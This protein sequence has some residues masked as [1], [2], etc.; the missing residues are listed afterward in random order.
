MA[1]LCETEGATAGAARR[2]RRR[3]ALLASC[4]ANVFEEAREVAIKA[5]EHL[6]DRFLSGAQQP[7]RIREFAGKSCTP[8][9]NGAGLRFCPRG[10]E[11][12]FQ[13]ADQAG[14][15]LRRTLGP[16]F[17]GPRRGRDGGSGFS[18]LSQSSCSPHIALNSSPLAADLRER[19]APP[20]EFSLL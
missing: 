10:R 4:L 15:F 1:A 14:Q 13:P 3:P 12:E 11:V 20:R 18:S 16:E 17:R 8:V 19:P 6:V 5:V 7:Q 2:I 9:W